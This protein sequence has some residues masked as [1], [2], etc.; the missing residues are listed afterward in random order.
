VLQ[1]VGRAVVGERVVEFRV[2][3]Q[4]VGAP[5]HL[6]E[7]FAGLL[8]R[9]AHRINVDVVA[10]HVGAQADQV[11]L[12]TNDIHDLVAAQHAFRDAVLLTLLAARF[13]RDSHVLRVRE[14]KA[15]EGVRRPA[16]LAR[17]W[18]EDEPHAVQ[19]VQIVRAGLPA[20]GGCAARIIPEVANVVQLD[21]R[22]VDGR[23]GQH[24]LPRRPL[25]RIAGPNQER[26]CN[27]RNECN[28]DNE[29]EQL[30]GAG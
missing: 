11:T 16:V 13:H 2:L 23:P 14:T 24:F 17:E 21:V 8:R 19:L 20:F 15:Q 26:K 6:H 3:V 9:C 27:E 30:H 4:P 25:A 7:Q 22:A 1:D 12:I 10:A 18:R 28:D 5:Q 29:E